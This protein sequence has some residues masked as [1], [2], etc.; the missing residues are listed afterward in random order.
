[1]RKILF[2]AT[3][4]IAVP[5]L[6]ALHEAGLVRAVLTCPD[7]KGKRG[8]E[9]LPSPIKIEALKLGLP[10]SQPE[11]LGKIA[12]IEVSLT[13]AD[14]LLSFCYGK[15]FGPKFLSLFDGEAYNIHPSLLPKY[16]GASPLEAALLNGDEKSGITLQ[17]LALSCDCGD[18]VKVEGFDIKDSDNLQTLTELVASKAVFVKDIFM[19]DKK[20]ESYPQEGEPSFAPLINKED[21]CM[22]FSLPAHKINGMIRAYYPWPKVVC[23]YKGMKLFLCSTSSFSDEGENENEGYVAEFD[24]KLGFRIVLKK[25]SIWINRLQL[26]TKKEMD[27]VSFHN[28]NPQFLGSRLEVI[29]E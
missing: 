27:A 9:L 21:A 1:M 25:G 16:R 3:G 20:I 6:R 17:R 11:T 10:V 19:D 2:A 15:I 8:C 28:G 22:D 29:R 18:I 4:E 24:R 7:K 12:R 26:A 13:G 23:L 14:T 5:T